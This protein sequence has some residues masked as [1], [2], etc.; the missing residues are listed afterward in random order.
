[1][2][3][4]D[5]SAGR[6]ALGLY[7]EAMGHLRDSHARLATTFKDFAQHMNATTNNMMALLDKEELRKYQQGR[8]AIEDA[9]AKRAQDLQEE[10]FKHSQAQDAL[11]AAFKQQGLDLQKKQMDFNQDQARFSNQLQKQQVANQTRDSKA[12][13]QL[14]RAQ[15]QGQLGQNYGFGK[16]MTTSYDPKDIN[17]GLQLQKGLDFKTPKPSL[18]VMTRP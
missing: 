12:R 16:V 9:R 8:H 13:A 11:G 1:M 2:T 18:G 3:P 10:A 5:I 14:L 7:N 4:P 6:G 17:A 15:A